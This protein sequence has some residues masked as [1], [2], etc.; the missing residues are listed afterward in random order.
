MKCTR[1]FAVC[2]FALIALNAPPALAQKPA[3]NSPNFGTVVREGKH[4]R[5]TVLISIDQFRGDYLSRWTNLFL[6]PKQGSNIG[7]FRYLME[8]G[9]YFVNAHHDHYPTYTGPGH[10]ALLTGATPNL[11]GIVSNNWWSLSPS[12]DKLSK[13]PKS[14]YNVYC[15]EDYSVSAIT[16]APSKAKPMSPRNLLSTTVGDELKLATNLR[17]KQVSL[18][19][20]DRAAILLAGHRPDI[21]LWYDEESKGWISSSY[22]CPTNH[23][24]DWVERRNHQQREAPKVWKSS[25]PPEAYKNCLPE[26]GAL[27][28]EVKGFEHAIGT[29]KGQIKISLSPFANEFVME[30]AE[31]A[32]KNEKLGQNDSATDMLTINLSTNDYVGHKFGPYSAEALDITVETDKV[33][34]KFLN[35]LNTSVPGGLNSCLIVI[36]GDHG[37]API[38]EAAQELGIHGGRIFAEELVTKVEKAL[39]ARF[40]EQNWLSDKG[41]YE[42]PYLY[43]NPDAVKKSIELGTATSKTDCERVAAQAVSELTGVYVAYTRTQLLSGEFPSNAISRRVA[44][45]FHSRLSGDILVVPEQGYIFTDSKTGTSHGTPFAYDTHVPILISGFGVRSGVWAERV[46]TLDIAPTLSLLLGVEFPSGCVGKPLAP[47]LR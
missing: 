36:T 31:K 6:P 18:A 38:P 4:P 19:L 16:S 45:G 7:G 47:A 10:A 29:E 27:P 1:L 40:G 8:A 9:S 46:S 35:F 28:R 15:V 13:A 42:E 30:S 33:L 5:L 37:V 34:S 12:A 17:S 2:S 11:H 32:V 41:T 22:Y 23:L 24:P 20:K 43:L 39:N 25:L 44:S 21:C 14:P 26:P 3:T